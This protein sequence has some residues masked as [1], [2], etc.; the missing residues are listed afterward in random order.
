MDKNL[1]QLVDGFFTGILSTY[2]FN[3]LDKVLYLMIKNKTPIIS[4]INFD[5]KKYT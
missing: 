1:Q 4:T 5:N 3:P 2:L